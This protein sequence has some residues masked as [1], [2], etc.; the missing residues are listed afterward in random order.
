[1]PNGKVEA[2][3]KFTPGHIVITS[4]EPL[5]F[6][7]G[8][9]TEDPHTLSIVDASEVPADIDSV[10]NCGSPGTVCDQIFQQFPGQPSGAQFVN[11]SGGAGLDGHFDTL[12]IEPGTSI[13]EPVTAPPGSTLYFI[14]AIHAWMQ[15]T[16]DVR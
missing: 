6:E 7:H 9:K 10:F 1:M 16:I 12:Y 4:G 14:C 5:T 8:D 13:T 11:V 3:L 2:N 15:G